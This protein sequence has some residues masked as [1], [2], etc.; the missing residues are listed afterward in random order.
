M[1]N[2]RSNNFVR[3]LFFVGIL[4][5]SGC[6]K[7]ESVDPIVDQDIQVN[8]PNLKAGSTAVMLETFTLTSTKWT[9]ISAG[10]PYWK[11]AG[12]TLIWFPPCSYSADTYGYLPT[13]WYSY[14]NSRGSSSQLAAAISAVKNNGM[15]AIA[16]VVLNHRNGNATAGAD[17]VNPAFANNAASV[18]KNDE[19]GCGTGAN[20]TGTGQSNGRDLDHTNTD[21]QSKC[22]AYVSSM[23]G[24]GFGGGRFDMCLGYAAKYAAMYKTGGFNVGEYWVSSRSTINSWIG[25]SGMNAFDFPT[26]NALKTAVAGNY[27][28]LAGVPGLIGIN[29]SHAVTFAGNHDASSSG[30]L[31]NVYIL[32]HPGV[33][34]VFINDWNSYSSAISTLIALRKSAGIGQTSSVAIQ[35]ATSSVYAAIIDGKLAMKIGPG[36]WSPSGSW[37]L[38]TSGTNYAIWTNF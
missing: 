8:N 32:T 25:T 28:A 35:T 34:C 17:F 31:G 18:V 2:Y 26:Y 6:S 21:V 4:I 3:C 13:Q 11:T 29:A 22:K 30:L 7:D 14:N 9:D 27:A 5:V 33:P 24:L 19:C 36:S 20:D 38:K 15:T 23:M 10:A 1:K 16:D 37:T 12:F